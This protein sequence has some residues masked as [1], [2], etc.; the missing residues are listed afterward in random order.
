M[1]LLNAIWDTA[2]HLKAQ[3]IC[4]S[5]NKIAYFVTHSKDRKDTLSP[6]VIWIVTHP[7]TT[8]T[9]NVHNAF[10]D[11]LILLRANGVEGTVVE[12]HKG[13]IEK[14]SSPH[15]LHVTHNIN[16][17]HYVCCFLTTALG[18]PIATVERE[19]NDAQGSVTLFFHE[20]KDKYGTLSAEV[21]GVSNCHVL[22]RDTTID[23]EFKGAGTPPQHV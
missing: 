5:A 3:K 17:T 6:I 14:L 19:V 23:Y 18:M 1:T 22:H 13:A 9:K 16:P 21:F 20:N 7:T 4:Y 2:S 15:L 8:T 11:I 12:W 10:P